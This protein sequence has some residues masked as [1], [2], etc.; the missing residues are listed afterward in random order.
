MPISEVSLGV[1]QHAVPQNIMQVEFKV[2]GEL[3]MRQFAYLVL[4]AVFA[5][6]TFASG[7]PKFIAIPLALCVAGLALAV[8]FLPIQDRSM[9]IWVV[10]FFLAIYSPTQRIWK[11][12]VEPPSYFLYQNANQL[13]NE[14]LAVAPTASRRKLE[15]YLEREVTDHILDPME[16]REAE[17][18]QK[19]RD[20]FE[21]T[22]TTQAQAST[23]QA[24]LFKP[25][26]SFQSQQTSV[27]DTPVAS[28]PLAQ[29]TSLPPIRTEPSINKN[30]Q[31]NKPQGI[32]EN[33]METTPAQ[34][35]APQVK[36]EI[37]PQL[38]EPKP[39]LAEQ[40]QSQPP[41]ASKEPAMPKPTATTQT[42]SSVPTPSPVSAQPTPAQAQTQQPIRTQPQVQAQIQ[43]TATSKPELKP[44][45]LPKESPKPEFKSQTQLTPT[46]VS[47]AFRV[48]DNVRKPKIT[49]TP[50]NSITPDRLTGRRF[51]HLTAEQG[52]LVLPIRGE[53]VLNTVNEEQKFDSDLEKKT[54]DLMGLI[55][56][57]KKEAGVQQAKLGAKLDLKSQTPTQTEATKKEVQSAANQL[58]SSND[59]LS[60]EIEELKRKMQDSSAAD[61]QKFEM[62]LLRLQNEKKVADTQI[63]ALQQKINELQQRL[64]QTVQTQKQTY[65]IPQPI[66]KAPE[67]PKNQGIVIEPLNLPET[68]PDPASVKAPEQTPQPVILKPVVP[69]P[70]KEA[71]IEAKPANFAQAPSFANQPN[72][73]NGIVKDKEG[74]L[75]EG[76][77]VIIKDSKEDVV[78]AL[79]TNKLG[80]FCIT[81]PVTNGRYKIEVTKPNEDIPQTFEPASVE[82]KGEV[83]PP[84]EFI[85][86]L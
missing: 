22:T 77:V 82:V 40:T 61:K 18:I 81:T 3:T 31:E 12:E 4:G 80:Q 79:K 39:K 37:K 30:F 72:L 33:A 64:Y 68:T 43:Q 19:V 56:R 60:K 24:T 44:Q 76:A 27:I 46:A 49:Y 74:K 11:K 17:Y 9:D 8:A 20:S 78:R 13:K 47:N 42:Q 85:G 73:I 62:E 34:T 7:L 2:I 59:N 75:V 71:P 15:Q 52:E 41:M 48:N 86:K 36:P 84:V 32:E 26:H 70:I 57:I 1:K 54:K 14:M 63:S 51:T 28:T 67:P 69:P 66:Q 50:Y 45:I 35:P 38:Q 83:L 5:F 23:K 10:N 6:G 58:K 55:D 25:Y 53:R 21:G 16:Q 65:D 29:D